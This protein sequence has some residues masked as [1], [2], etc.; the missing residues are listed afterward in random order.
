MR[1]PPWPS[2][3]RQA[4]D[5][6]V[7]GQPDGA[8]STVPVP[9]RHEHRAADASAPG[10]LRPDDVHAFARYGGAHVTVLIAKQTHPPGDP[11]LALEPRQSGLSGRGQAHAVHSSST[12]VESL[13]STSTPLIV[14]ATDP[15]GAV[16]KAYVKYGTGVPYAV[17]HS[18]LNGKR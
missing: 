17:Y 14:I 11:Q 2:L 1:S 15:E 16:E 7:S 4:D 18:S 6:T 3:T 10:E 5:V 12:E 13:Y 9:R 8:D